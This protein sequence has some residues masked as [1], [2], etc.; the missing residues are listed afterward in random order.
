LQQIIGQIRIEESLLTEG[1]APVCHIHL[2]QSPLGFCHLFH[3]K[4]KRV[5][6]M[7]LSGLLHHLKKPNAQELEVLASP[8]HQSSIIINTQKKAVCKFS[9]DLLQKTA[10]T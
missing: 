8:V 10:T 5:P 7:H 9:Y 4:D 6:S 2:P 1:A 3:Q